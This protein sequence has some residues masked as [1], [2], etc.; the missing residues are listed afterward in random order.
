M[1]KTIHL[2]LLLILA[3]VAAVAQ[4][5]TFFFPQIAD[6]GPNPIF[7]TAIVLINNGDV[8]ANGTIRFVRPDGTPFVLTLKDGRTGSEFTFKLEPK[9]T[10]LLETT[11][12]GQL[13]NGYAVVTSDR[14]IGGTAIFSQFDAT[15][16][17][18]T[19]AGVPASP[20]LN[21]FTIFVD[22][23][24]GFNTGLAIAN[25]GST[26][27]NL[28]FRLL[29]LDSSPLAVTPAT[30]TLG[31]NQHRAQFVTE[32]SEFGNASA[33]VVGSLEVSA[34]APVSAVT[35]RTS[36]SSLT[37]TPIVPRPA[38]AKIS[39]GSSEAILE[40]VT[41]GEAEEGGVAVTLE[42]GDSPEP[43]QSFILRFMRGGALIQEQIEAAARGKSQFRFVA[44]SLTISD[45]DQVHIRPV[46]A[47]GLLGKSSIHK[48]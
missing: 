32:F 7:R 27:S 37:T 24:T 12:E 18:V 38:A 43:I 28:T 45:I 9:Q 15:G 20:N 10:A 16:K 40:R 6:G 42:V 44:G 8:V 47:S 33:N 11:G 1:R 46:F 5:L 30:L 39:T 22:T 3:S 48:K 41:L 25:A 19:E 2:A 23:R 31:A 4:Q 26:A 13:R 21:N 34:T 17:L 36:P 29:K 35:L 14:T